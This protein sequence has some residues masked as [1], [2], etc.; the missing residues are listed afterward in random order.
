MQYLTGQRYKNLLEE[1]AK[2]DADRK[3]KTALAIRVWH[4]AGTQKNASGWK[5][6]DHSRPLHIA[7]APFLKPTY[8]IKVSVR[9][10]SALT[11]P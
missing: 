11:Y 10:T 1:K 8:P 3:Q 4:C 9:T 6:R 2:E 7:I 5:W